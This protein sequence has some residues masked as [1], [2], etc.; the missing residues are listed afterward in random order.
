MGLASP[1]KNG[2][3]SKDDYHDR[4]IPSDAN[5]MLLTGNYIGNP[6]NSPGNGSFIFIVIAR[7]LYILQFAWDVTNLNLY[8]RSTTNKGSTWSEWKNL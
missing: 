2:L 4:S 5:D 7:N 8:I 6:L 3:K 1:S